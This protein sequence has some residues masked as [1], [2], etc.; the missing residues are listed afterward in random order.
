MSAIANTATKGLQKTMANPMVSRS[1]KPIARR[2]IPEIDN[3]MSGFYAGG[4]LAAA[5]AAVPKVVQGIARGINRE[6]NPTQLRQNKLFHESGITAGTQKVA[7]RE[8]KF[9]ESPAVTAVLEKRQAKQPLSDKD[10]ELIKKVN[11]SGKVL[12]GQIEWNNLVSKQYG[13]DTPLFDKT[14]ALDNYYG[15]P[16]PATTENMAKGFSLHKPWIYNE[17]MPKGLDSEIVNHIKEVQGLGDT[18]DKDVLM[19]IKKP[20]SSNAA[21]NLIANMNKKANNRKI[22][23]KVIRSY[24]KPFETTEALHKAL[25]KAGVK[26][27]MSKE[28]DVVLFQDSFS[29]SSYSLGGVNNH[30]FMKKDGVIGSTISD[31]NDIS[32]F[33]MPGGK[34]GL[35]ITPTYFE[36]VLSLK[37]VAKAKFKRKNKQKLTKREGELLLKEKKREGDWREQNQSELSDNSPMSKAMQTAGLNKRQVFLVKKIIASGASPLEV[38]DYI[39]YLAKVGGTG[40]AVGG[41]LSGED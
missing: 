26:N 25:T 36:N 27:R 8:S 17:Q 28:H 22:A 12:E 30:S 35:S 19:F 2:L 11:E 18:A 3:K 24:G 9:L 39:K 14:V 40:V 21:G 5:G 31:K 15:Q 16:L 29:S 34:T 20:N 1:V 6:L 37:G 10:N 13:M 41:M 4:K 33:D 38:K 32:V 23:K 7:S